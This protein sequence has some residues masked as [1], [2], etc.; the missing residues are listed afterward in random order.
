MSVLSIAFQEKED[1]VLILQEDKSTHVHYVHYIRLSYLFCYKREI[2]SQK[3]T[4]LLDFFMHLYCT[5]S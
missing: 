1:V 3:E 4:K 2:P 5:Y